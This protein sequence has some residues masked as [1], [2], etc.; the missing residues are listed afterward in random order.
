MSAVNAAAV[1]ARAAGPLGSEDP[2]RTALV[3]LAALGV[4]A[5]A[6][7]HLRVGRRRW[8]P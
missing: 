1:R 8:S 4:L 3:A 7:A 6:V 2:A 5:G